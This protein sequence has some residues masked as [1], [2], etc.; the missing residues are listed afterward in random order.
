MTIKGSYGEE[1]NTVLLRLN[2]LLQNGYF[3][4]VSKDRVY[5]RESDS[6]D[7]IASEFVSLNHRFKRELNLY[8]NPDGLITQQKTFPLSEEDPNEIR[9]HEEEHEK[10]LKFVRELPKVNLFHKIFSFYLRLR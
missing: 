2:I 8:L 7:F 10:F 4:D 9:I 5:Y 1:I 6:F 3:I